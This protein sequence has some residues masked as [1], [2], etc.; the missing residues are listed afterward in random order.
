MRLYKTVDYDKE[1][2]SK[3]RNGEYPNWVIV[4]ENGLYCDIEEKL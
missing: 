4:F 3:I 1:M 2:I